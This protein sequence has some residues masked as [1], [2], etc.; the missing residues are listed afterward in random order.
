MP[1]S[2]PIVRGAILQELW[3]AARYGREYA[4]A[5]LRAAGVEPDE[6]GF[7]S[8]IG[9]MQPVTR[10][11]LSQATGMRR[12][13]VRDVVARRIERGQIAERPNPG[14]GRST[15]LVLTPVGQEIFDRCSTPSS[16]SWTPRSPATCMDTRTRCTACASRSRCSVAGRR[17][18]DGRT[19]TQRSSSA[20]VK[21][22]IQFVSHVRPPSSENACSQRG[23]VVVTRDQT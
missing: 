20:R 13:T 16:P 12:T 15:L 8:F 11:R 6:Y 23:V 10:T 9:V 1:A 7:L 17:R 4:N 22:M 3:I 14:D 5:A 18:S 21:S 2:E 19:T